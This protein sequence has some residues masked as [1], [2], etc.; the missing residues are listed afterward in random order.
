MVRQTI[1]MPMVA[2]GEFFSLSEMGEFQVEMEF[3]FSS[4]PHFIKGFIDLVFCHRGRVYFL[5]WKTNWLED[6][7][8]D[9]LK[10]AIDAHDYGL[11][12]AL[13]KEAIK[14]HFQMEYGGAYYLF[15]RGGAYLKVF[16]EG[17]KLFG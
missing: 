14:R 6:Y 12:A 11:Q 5:D 2:E 8:Q 3:V 7:G 15:V 10:K 1:A 4:P 16:T 13:Y 17:L 9:S